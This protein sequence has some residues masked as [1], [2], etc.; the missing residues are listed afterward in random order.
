[1]HLPHLPAFQ[2]TPILFLT[3]CTRG[4]QLLLADPTPHGILHDVWTR[5]ADLNGWFVGQYILMPDHVHLFAQ[6]GAEALPLAVWTRTWKSISAT[7]I[8]RSIGCSGAMR[9]PDYFDRYLRSLE[10]YR[11]KWEY[12]A[13]NPVRKGLVANADDW[14]YRGLIHDLRHRASRG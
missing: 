10:D 1:M 12:V 5:S 11:Q 8:N 2:R 3:V 13:Q 6:A 7:R 9:Q 4:R 14:P